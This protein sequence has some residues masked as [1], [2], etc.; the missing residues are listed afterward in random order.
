MNFP[1]V[2]EDCV[3][4]HQKLVPQLLPYSADYYRQ[5]IQNSFLFF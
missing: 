5:Q 4:H 1:V 2:E 3:L